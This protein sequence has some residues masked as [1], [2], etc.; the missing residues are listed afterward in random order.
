MTSSPKNESPSSIEEWP[1]DYRIF[2]S[3]FLK[4]KRDSVAQRLLERYSKHTRAWTADKNSE[5]FCR[6]YF[7]AKLI[8]AATLHINALQYAAE[9]NLRVVI[10]YLRYYSVLSTIRA[11][12]LTLPEVE[13][14]DGGVLAVSHAVAID[15]TIEFIRSLDS[16]YSKILEEKISQLKEERELISYRAPSSGDREIQGQRSEIELCTL[17]SEVA[18]FNSELLRQSLARHASSLKFEFKSEYFE[19]IYL[20]RVGGQDFFDEQDHIRLGQF[21]RKNPRLSNIRSMM[22]EGHVDDFFGSWLKPDEDDDDIEALGT[23]FNPDKNHLVIF[24][25]P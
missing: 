10:P 13:W 6:F 24:D 12:H 1:Y 22:K 14:A 15:R 18:Q 17:F 25:I 23:A 11:I 7:G 4:V 16:D 20:P 3:K 2:N 8:M 19:H 5:W 21:A 9:R